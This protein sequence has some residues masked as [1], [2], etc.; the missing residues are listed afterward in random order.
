VINAKANPALRRILLDSQIIYISYSNNN[1]YGETSYV[2]NLIRPFNQLKM[3]MK[4]LDLILV[5][6]L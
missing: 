5:Y 3:I 6:Q 2:E 4:I 1:E